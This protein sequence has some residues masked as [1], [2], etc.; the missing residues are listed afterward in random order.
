MR[1]I[2]FSKN[3]KIGLAVAFLILLITSGWFG[4]KC[5]LEKNCNAEVINKFV[6]HDVTITLPQGAIVAEVADTPAS[7]ELGLSGRA[8]LRENEGMLFIFDYPGKYGFWMKDMLFSL[9]I[10]W[11]NQNGV[12][13]HIERNVTPESYSGVAPRSNPQTFVNTIDASYVLEIAAGMSDKYGVYL[14]SKVKIGE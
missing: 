7:R 10:I 1:K 6:R 2:K 12:V 14:G 4:N 8:G 11:I 13:V 5:F 3:E 9:D